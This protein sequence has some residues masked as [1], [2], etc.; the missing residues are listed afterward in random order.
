MILFGVRHRTCAPTGSSR[1][2][3]LTYDDALR[4]LESLPCPSSY[5]VFNYIKEA[6]K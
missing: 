4:Y 6:K 3:F 1:K 5:E 2:G